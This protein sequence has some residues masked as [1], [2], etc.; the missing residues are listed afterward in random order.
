VTAMAT[1]EE[2]RTKITEEMARKV[3]EKEA[4]NKSFYHKYSRFI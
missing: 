3:I 4:L 1:L 2:K